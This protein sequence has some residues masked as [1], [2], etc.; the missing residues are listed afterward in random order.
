METNRITKIYA[1]FVDDVVDFVCHIIFCFNT[2]VVTAYMHIFSF[3]CVLSLCFPF[4]PDARV[5]HHNRLL[6]APFTYTAPLTASELKF[7]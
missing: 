5:L 1:F 2:A 3:F 7:I 4:V 6:C